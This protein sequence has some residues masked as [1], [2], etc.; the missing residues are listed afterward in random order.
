MKG[1]LFVVVLGSILA[2]SAVAGDKSACHARSLAGKW[3]FATDVGRQNLFPGGDI[4]AIGIFTLDRKGGAKGRFDA[5][6]A[7]LTFLPKV[8]F[9][10]TL[11]VKPDCTG[12]FTFV[13]GAGT[14]RTDSIVVLSPWRIRGMSQDVNNLWTYEM[15]RL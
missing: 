6:I 1:S 13:T 3:M 9:E 10:G 12:T 5:T 4:T 14:Q 8:P 11:E 15:E 7:D 2:H